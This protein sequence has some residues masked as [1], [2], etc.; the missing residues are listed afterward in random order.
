MEKGKI[1]KT[2]S[3][4]VIGA[5]LRAGLVDAW[6]ALYGLKPFTITYLFI[7][8]DKDKLKLTNLC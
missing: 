7:L 5:Y 8:K 4:K 6:T 2:N 1:Y 3:E